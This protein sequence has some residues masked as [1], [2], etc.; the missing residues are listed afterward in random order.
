[1]QKK[2]TIIIVNEARVAVPLVVLITLLNQISC[3]FFGRV[4]VY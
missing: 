3:V 4:A 2:Q 1:M